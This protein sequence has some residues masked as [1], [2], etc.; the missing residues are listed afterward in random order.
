MKTKTDKRS[1]K[2]ADIIHGKVLYRPVQ[3]KNDL[4]QLIYVDYEQI[5]AHYNPQQNYW[6]IG[7]IVM[8][9][10]R[11]RSNKL[12][13]TS[14]KVISMSGFVDP[15]YDK[16]NIKLTTNQLKKIIKKYKIVTPLNEEYNSIKKL[17][18]ID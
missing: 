6:Q 14:V 13:P 7:I 2:L 16:V 9:N 18:N 4:G 5:K 8:S 12:W 1:L 11:F 17:L 15:F 3:D 10:Y